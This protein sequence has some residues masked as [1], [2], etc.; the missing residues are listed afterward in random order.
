MRLQDASQK[1]IALMEVTDINAW[2]L[3]LPAVMRAVLG[4]GMK[5]GGKAASAQCKKYI[6]HIDSR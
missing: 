1:A 5:I 4:Q 6:Q 2:L 3:F